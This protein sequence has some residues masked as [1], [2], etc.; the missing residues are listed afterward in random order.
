MPV[1]VDGAVA[2][3]AFQAKTIF[4]GLN[5]LAVLPADG[6]DEVRIR[7]RAFQ[8]I[9]LAEE[10]HLRH[11]EQIPGQHQQGQGVGREQPL[12]SHVVD[13]ENCADIAEGGIFGVDGAQQNRD[14]SGLPV[15][16]VKNIGD[17]QDFRGFEHSTGEQSKALGVVGIVSSGGS[18][19]RFAIEVGRI[20]DEI[21]T[22]R[23]L[24]LPPLTTE[25]KRYWSSKGTVTLRTTVR[26]R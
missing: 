5:F 26:A 11:G 18:V 9:H 23:R 22:S 14:Q 7:Q 19:E 15:V 24:E 21:E 25:A 6:G 8:E 17:A 13:G 4:R 10:F 12:I 20:F 2:Q 16:T 3:H 1:T